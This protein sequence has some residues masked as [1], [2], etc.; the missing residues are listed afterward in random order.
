MPQTA[1]K[2]PLRDTQSEADAADV[3]V[4]LAVADAW[5]GGEPA[6]NVSSGAE[7]GCVRGMSPEVRSA[8]S[9]PGCNQHAACNMSQRRMEEGQMVIVRVLLTGLICV[10][11][12]NMTNGLP[13]EIHFLAGRDNMSTLREECVVLAVQDAVLKRTSQLSSN[14][15]DSEQLAVHSQHGLGGRTAA[16]SVTRQR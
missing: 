3:E 7:D 16:R 9:T 10:G 2:Q 13:T 12:S 1:C 14:S 6:A 8:C 4:A 15:N 5:A 11:I